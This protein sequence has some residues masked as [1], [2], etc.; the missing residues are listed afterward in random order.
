MYT[1]PHPD[2][3][4]H[5]HNLHHTDGRT[6]WVERLTY[7][8]YK[9]TQYIIYTHRLGE[10]VVERREEVVLQEEGAQPR[11]HTEPLQR[12]N[13]LVGQRQR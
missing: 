5:I 9:H 6:G 7:Y 3:H 10:E 12:R 1:Q 8:T 13:V 11:L 4:T 2:T